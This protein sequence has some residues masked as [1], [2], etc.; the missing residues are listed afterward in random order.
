MYSHCKVHWGCFSSSTSLQ[1]FY[2]F[3]A[4]I[5]INSNSIQNC[6]CQDY[7]AVAQNIYDCTIYLQ[8]TSS[9]VVNCFMHVF[10]HLI[11]TGGQKE[12]ETVSRFLKVNTFLYILK[13]WYHTPSKIYP[14]SKFSKECPRGFFLVALKWQVLCK[15]C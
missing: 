11:Q 9:L 15:C 4:C 1:S 8:R 14:L 5:G 2:N 10:L 12:L 6:E 7:G 13:D 3:F